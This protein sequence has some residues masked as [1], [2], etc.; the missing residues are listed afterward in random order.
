M[1]EFNYPEVTPCLARRS[2][3]LRTLYLK[4]RRRSETRMSASV[5]K[6]DPNTYKIPKN[7]YLYVSDVLSGQQLVERNKYKKV[8][9]TNQQ[10]RVNH[11]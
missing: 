8:V 1:T 9:F 4:K 3:Q 6:Q 7:A 10:E 5:L 11:A 2:Y